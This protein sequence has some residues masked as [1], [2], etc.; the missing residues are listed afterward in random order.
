VKTKLVG[1]FTIAIIAI[2]P[3]SQAT[4]SGLTYLDSTWSSNEGEGGELIAI[5]P[6]GTILASYHGDDIIL[7]NT[8]TLES[9][10][11]FTFGE[12]IAG[13]EFN[14][15]GSLLAINKRSAVTLKESIKLI[16]INSMEVLES[17]VLADDR[18]RDLSWSIDGKILAAQGND[19]NGDVEQ[20]H[21]PSLY[22][23]NSL[24]D[25]HVVD[26]TC[27]DY[28]SDGQYLL[29]GDESG[30][31]AVWNLQGELQSNYKTY[32]EGI[33]DC[34]FSPD[35]SDIV[36]L[37][38]NGKLVS[39]VFGGSE[40]YTE[41]VE[42]AKQI[43][44]PKVGNRMHLSVESDEFRGLLSYD[45][46]SF[47]PLTNT[48]FFH[49]VEDVAFTENDY[50]RIQSLFVAGGTGE[51]A[52]Y[53]RELIPNGFN[54]PGVDLDGDLVPDD[55]DPDDDGD[56]I[57]DDWD[58]DM[59]CDAP[60]GTPCSRYP[61][62]DKIRSIEIYVGEKFAVSD[63]IT[64]P[65]ED[66]SHIRNLSRNAVAKDNVISSSE[67]EL[68]GNAM[69]LNMDHG[70]I[71]DKWRESIEL[72]NGELGDATVSC[73]VLDGMEL[74]RDGD[75][76]TQITILI[77]TT[78]NYSTVVSLPLDISL[79]EQPLPAD[80]SIAWL[81]PAHPISL[82]FKGDGVEANEISL[83]W[84]NEDDVATVTI[85]QVSVKN[86]EFFE[87]VLELA[88]NPFAFILYLGIA[89]GSVT[90]LI[91][92]SNR[93]EFDL[94][95]DVEDSGEEE[96]TEEFH[97][98]D[99]ISEIEFDL[100]DYEQEDITPS[101]RTP[102]PKKRKMYTTTEHNSLLV[103]KKRITTSQLNVEG[104]I[105]KTKRKR[106]VAK[107]E[108]SQSVKDVAPI[109]AKTQQK[110]KTRKVKV[111]VPKSKPEKKNRKP[112]KRKTKK[113]NSDHSSNKESKESS[114]QKEDPVIDENELQGNLLNDFTGND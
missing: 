22:V 36:L 88:L 8:T 77:T 60:S 87:I 18:F 72:S 85:N 15:N 31:W 29:T 43:I 62:L 58:D 67:A 79:R 21:V 39:K 17:S 84:N 110:I 44:F 38:E 109:E 91:R 107:D 65:T 37:G 64:L 52:V 51:I 42:G 50:G 7:F 26:V 78:F 57:I 101:K 96:E 93:I 105:T 19:G 81:A 106:L 63:Q 69:C 94:D 55:L 33:I 73:S 114:N 48:S 61:D 103:K 102:P 76:T 25:V 104:P 80:G 66:S 54:Q 10:G 100:D 56:G 3:L 95:D 40:K 20:Y 47:S 112:V 1:F 59:G 82:T 32:S 16:D 111:E 14:P 2:C 90:I 34:H 28:R 27:I 11:E 74:V 9:I 30:R 24:I 71:I 97:E 86:P 89:I 83:W 41:N 23:K 53:L 13:M 75:S 92:R 98:Q 5:N 46:N 108:D 99:E 68:F 70:D 6:N 12:D 45:Y 4:P 113:K 49:K 35:G